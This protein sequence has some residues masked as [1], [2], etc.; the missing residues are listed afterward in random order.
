LG[1]SA[2]LRFNGKNDFSVNGGFGAAILG[3]KTTIDVAKFFFERNSVDRNIE[4]GVYL[5]DIKIPFSLTGNNITDNTGP[6]IILDGETFAH[7]DSNNITG[8]GKGILIRDLATARINDNTITGNGKG[9]ALAGTGTGTSITH[10]TIFNN[11]GLGIDLGD[12]GVTFNDPGDA[13]TG[14]NNLQNFPALTTAVSSGGNTD[15]RGT[16]NSAANTSYKLELFSNPT[17][18]SSGFGEGQQFL[19]SVKVTTDASGNASFS[20]TLVG[21]TLPN[22]SAVTA[23]ATDPDNNTSEFSACLLA[24][25][26]LT[27]ADLEVNKKADKTSLLVNDPVNFTITLLNKGPKEATTIKVRDILPFGITFNAANAS[28]GTYDNTTG[29]WSVN[30]LGNGDTA[31]LAIVGVVNQ[32]GTIMNQVNIIASDQP[33]PDSANNQDSVTI[34][35]QQNADL[36]VTKNA[37]VTTVPLGNNVVFTV[38]LSNLGPGQATGIIIKDLLPAGFIFSQATPSTGNYNST[39]GLWTIASLDAGSKATL[40][41]TAATAQAGNL[42]N[43]ALVTA[44]DQPDPNSTNNQ[45]SVTITVQASS[46][47]EMLYADLIRQINNLVSQRQLTVHRGRLLTGLVNVSL[48]LEKQGNIRAAIEVLRIF[49]F[50]VNSLSR[51]GNLSSV[52]ALVLTNAAR[53]II[54]QLR[55]QMPV[56]GGPG[57]SEAYER[58]VMQEGNKLLETDKNIVVNSYPNPFTTY[59]IIA[60]DLNHTG[61]VQV[62]VYDVGGRLISKLV[63]AVLLEGHHTIN[64][65]PGSSLSPGVYIVKLISGNVISTQRLVYIK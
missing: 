45:G 4:G 2:E 59:T 5:F 62:L 60:F 43:S 28:V 7:I 49:D 22:G 9:I 26:T 53:N 48:K 47:I 3:D 35:V 44:S 65:Q 32:V 40:N 56:K 25:G 6:G 10:N 30:S 11:T 52:N 46:N 41:I 17:C 37:N 1:G 50:I 24:G 15:I 27:A 51:R 58:Q 39:T 34:T 23:T 14:P 18:N 33:D 36:T 61:K 13:D 42:T 63:D 31:K 16:L 55:L 12:D 38:T 29:I 54:K 8:N 20:K 64:W 19:D 21:L 57:L